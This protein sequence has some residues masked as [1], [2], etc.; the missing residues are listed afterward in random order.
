MGEMESARQRVEELRGLLEEY[1]KAYYREG[2]SLVSDREFDLLMQEL[3]QLE[4]LHPELLTE[5]SPTQRVGDDSSDGFRKVPHRVPMLSL[6][7][8][9]SL[10]ELQDFDR[11]VREA[12]DHTPRYSVELKYDG[13]SIALIYREGRLV[14]AIT[15]G[16][17]SM[18]DDVTENARCI[19]N[20]PQELKGEGYPATL[21]MRGEVFVPRATFTRLNE[22]RERAN[23][24]LRAA[25][26]KELEPYANARN[27]ASG[28]LKLRTDYRA[29]VVAIRE[30]YAQKI[31]R[32]GDEKKRTSLARQEENAVKRAVAKGEA[33]HESLKNRGLECALYYV[34]QEGDVAGS[35]VGSLEEARAWGLP[36]V[37]RLRLCQDID[38]VFATIEEWGSERN[39]FPF[40]TDGIV[41]KVN[42]YADQ[43]AL[44]LTSKSP[45]W[46][47]AYKFP[48]ERVTTPLL[49]VEFQVGRTGAVT[50]VA[51][52]EA[53]HLGGST[54]RRATLHNA[55]EMERLDLREHDW[56]EVEKGGEVIPKIV[57]VSMDHRREAG[58]RILYPSHCPACGAK[59]ERNE[60]EARHYCPNSMS[61]PPQITGAIEHFASKKAM[62][63]MGL[64]EETVQALYEAGLLREV[65]DLYD[66]RA[67]QLPGIGRFGQDSANKL[68]Q[69]IEKSKQQ[70]FERLLFAL[71]IRHIGTTTAT[72]LART[73]G[74]LRTIASASLEEL[75]AVPD[76]GE[77][78]GQ[79]VYSYFRSE[80][81][82][83]L[84]NRIEALGLRTT[85]D[86]KEAVEVVSE[87]LAG[88]KVVVSGKFDAYSR[89]ELKALVAAHGG[90]IASSVSSKTSLIVAG[91]D[92][93]AS[94]L[95]K[96]QE[97]GI[98]IVNEEEFGK[99]IGRE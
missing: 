66:L 56:V 75:I 24:G 34:V 36:V 2:V 94:K 50:P 70:P 21:E 38:E 53:V 57:G 61:C 8:T 64:G 44:G 17:G 10:E 7:N 59:L 15:R 63:I 40:D 60:G 54:V 58:S 49:G 9:Y 3:T 72:K 84:M 25:G 39:D 91:R 98:R 11:R 28:S 85:A 93:G 41:V 81:S 30:K 67:E 97:L 68:V 69:A 73:F 76:V 87:V 35:H 37:E 5:D 77:I 18:G 55:D 96:A 62:N 51:N 29:E 78:V 52:L 47:I 48:T 19:L 45:R 22:E 83:A 80:K 27:L 23:E 1:N 99:M 4:R 90:T 46:A 86:E 13:L 12:L 89:D 6:D 14:Q 71:G 95:K 32:E 26:K 33:A 16:N 20:L 92:M 74:S 31:A 42:A 79:E 65:L 88:E 82:E 43:A